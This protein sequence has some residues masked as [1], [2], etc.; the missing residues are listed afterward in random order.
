MEKGDQ[1][2]QTRFECVRSSIMPHRLPVG[3][4][5]RSEIENCLQRGPNRRFSVRTHGGVRHDGHQNFKVTESTAPSA[6]TIVWS[7]SVND[8]ASFLEDPRNGYG[9]GENES[10]TNDDSAY[11]D[12]DFSEI[13][14]SSPTRS[15]TEKPRKHMRRFFSKLKRARSGFMFDPGEHVAIT[16]EDK[17]FD[18]RDTDLAKTCTEVA[19]VKRQFT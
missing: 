1:F 16:K 7:D 3:E 12:A 15:Q 2:Y 13:L 4:K 5:E 18:H 6:S 9:K 14:P 8:R 19:A 10:S 11:E 17:P